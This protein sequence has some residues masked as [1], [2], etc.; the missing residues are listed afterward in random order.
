MLDG[1]NAIEKRYIYRLMSNVQLQGSKL[2]DSQILMNYCTKNNDV[3]LAKEY[4]KHV[5]KENQKHGVIDQG[6]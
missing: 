4:Q 3:S 6:D 2:F 5:S 1:L